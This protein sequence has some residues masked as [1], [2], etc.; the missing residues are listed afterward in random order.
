MEK[1]L[2]VIA[3]SEKWFTPFFVHV[4]ANNVISEVIVKTTDEYTYYCTKCESRECIHSEAVSK[5]VFDKMEQTHD[6]LMERKNRV[7]K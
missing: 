3:E 5:H 6:E 1:V 2:A 4:I 7:K